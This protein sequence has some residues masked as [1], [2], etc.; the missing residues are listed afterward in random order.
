MAKKSP[1]EIF[2]GNAEAGAGVSDAVLE[3]DDDAAEPT[4]QTANESRAST[5]ERWRIIIDEAQDPQELTR[6]FVGCNGRG[7]WL[8]RGVPV[9]VP[10]EVIEILDH[11]VINRA[12][13][14]IDERTG[15]PNGVETREA[16]RFPFRVLGKVVDKF[17]RPVN[18]ETPGVY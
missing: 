8:Q 13:P 7:Y 3:I 18:L 16:K 2:V 14:I 10:P 17:G 15:L 11:A 4:R 6:V 5:K 1:T 12:I 9:D